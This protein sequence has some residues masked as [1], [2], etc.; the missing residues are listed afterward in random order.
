MGDNKDCL[1]TFHSHSRIFNNEHNSYPCCRYDIV[2]F[3]QILMC[4]FFFFV[5][6]QIVLR[7]FSNML[8]YLNGLH[9]KHQ[10]YLKT[11]IFFQKIQNSLNIEHKLQMNTHV[12]DATSGESLFL[13]HRCNIVGA[14]VYQNEIQEICVSCEFFYRIGKKLVMC[15]C[16]SFNKYL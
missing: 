1:S 4:V 9:L 16:C 12:S 5:V 11:N 8:T 15:I 10:T 6:E 13:F 3:N 7:A 14:W 2:L